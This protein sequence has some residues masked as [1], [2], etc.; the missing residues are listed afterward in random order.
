MQKCYFA[1]NVKTYLEIL[2]KKQLI[3]SSSENNGLKNGFELIF[4][5]DKDYWMTKISDQ[6][7]E[8]NPKNY[9]YAFLIEFDM[10]SNF[11]NTTMDNPAIS[12]ISD[13]IA[14]YYELVDKPLTM[15]L[16][17]PDETN[18]LCVLDAYQS[19]EN[20]DGI[21]QLWFIKVETEKSQLWL[22][23]CENVMSINA[24][25]SIPEAEELVKNL[26]K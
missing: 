1:T 24:V 11:I 9:E 10:N 21:G 6:P 16:L 20:A 14:G 23:F 2:S 12:R 25:G 19:E 18:I 13:A 7:D 26:P 22:D 17:T 3:L 5:E 4:S 8:Q 15:K